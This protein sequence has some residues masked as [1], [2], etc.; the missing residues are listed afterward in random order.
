MK[1]YTIWQNF[2]IN[3]DDWRDDYQE[4]HGL[5][6]D[7]MSEIGDNEVYQWA[8]YVNYSYLDDERCN[9]DI[10][11]GSEIIVIGDIGLWDG[12][13]RGYKIIKSGNIRDCLYD[14]ECD[15]CDWYCDGYDMRFTGAHHDG[16]NYYLYR[17]WKDGLTECQKDNFLA[18]MYQGSATHKDILRYTR[19][20]RPYISAVYG[21]GK[22][23]N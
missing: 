21:W 6:D 19:S 1:K 17:K 22:S 12:R 9:L 18:D 20:I 8:Y 5:S 13:V 4:C 10:N 7:E 11:V 2:D 3:A 14:E 23:I 16:R 15:F